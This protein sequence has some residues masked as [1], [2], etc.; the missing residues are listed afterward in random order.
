MFNMPQAQA[1]KAWMTTLLQSCLQIDSDSSLTGTPSTHRYSPVAIQPPRNWKLNPIPI[2]TTAPPTTHR[3]P[4]LNASLM[5]AIEDS[6]G[7]KYIAHRQKM[8]LVGE[9]SSE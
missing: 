6:N 7:G 8:L 3:Y 5:Q 1:L 2:P 9:G 4:S